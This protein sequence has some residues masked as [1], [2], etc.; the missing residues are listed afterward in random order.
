MALHSARRILIAGK[1]LNKNK[2]AA[3]PSPQTLFKSGHTRGELATTSAKT[4]T[5]IKTTPP[6]ASLSRKRRRTEAGG[7]AGACT[8]KSFNGEL[9][10]PRASEVHGRAQGLPGRPDQAAAWR[11]S[12]PSSSRA[13]FR[14]EPVHG[15]IKRE[16][17]DPSSRRPCPAPVNLPGFP[18]G[19]PLRTDPFRAL[20]W[21]SRAWCLG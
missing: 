6:A 21:R 1:K 4:A 9:T 19:H 3:H 8:G 17:L 7:W 14:S 20:G 12:S 11:R 15:A 16:R 2:G 10:R 13:T 5:L 18:R